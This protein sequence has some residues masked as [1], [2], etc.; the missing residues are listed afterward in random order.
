VI[1]LQDLARVLPQLDDSSE[2]IRSRK[3]HLYEPRACRTYEDIETQLAVLR[4]QE[5]VEESPVEADV[6]RLLADY[7]TVA[8]ALE[9]RMIKADPLVFMR[10][11]AR[12]RRHEALME[13]WPPVS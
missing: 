10:R 13:R 11:E 9:Q 12:E 8:L 4:W 3:F 2:R 1:G 7:D 6:V 5:G